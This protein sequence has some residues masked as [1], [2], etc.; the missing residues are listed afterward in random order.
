MSAGKWSV[1]DERDV[2]THARN[3]VAILE[4]HESK[5]KWGDPIWLFVRC[6]GSDLDIYIVW[7]EFLATDYISIRFDSAQQTRRIWPLSSD[8]M[9][10]FA[11]N[12]RRFY[13]E[14]LGAE[15]LAARIQPYNE[16]YRTAVFDLSGSEEALLPITTACQTTPRQKKR[17][18][19]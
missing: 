10:A 6:K 5:N 3:I 16:G 9:S 2:M 14:L 1:S 15:K 19:G 18:K 11:R 12:P 7:G 8:S 13:N 4:S 17:K